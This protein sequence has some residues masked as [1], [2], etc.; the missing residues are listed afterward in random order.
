[1]RINYIHYVHRELSLFVIMPKHDT[2]VKSLPKNTPGR[3]AP[4]PI[5]NEDLLAALNSVKTKLKS[6]L[7]FVRSQMAELRA[8]NASLCKRN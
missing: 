8:E 5:T 3:S 1:M 2:P 6:D 7:S 4:K